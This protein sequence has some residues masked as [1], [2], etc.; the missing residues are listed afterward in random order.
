MAI[1]RRVGRP[2]SGEARSVRVTA[3]L[4]PDVYRT[5][6]AL[7][8]QKRVSVAWIVRAAAEQYIAAQWPLFAGQQ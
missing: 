7:A 5:L 6:E 2:R 1:K 4:S 3:S 8:K